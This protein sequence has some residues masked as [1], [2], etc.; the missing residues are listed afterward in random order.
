MLRLPWTIKNHKMEVPSLGPVQGDPGTSQAP[1]TPTPWWL[2]SQ[3]GNWV[4][5]HELWHYRQHHPCWQWWRV[6]VMRLRKDRWSG[7]CFAGSTDCELRAHTCVRW[8]HN[9]V[10]W[11]LVCTI[12][13][14][15]IFIEMPPTTW[16]LGINLDVEE[17]V[18][19]DIYWPFLLCSLCFCIFGICTL[20]IERARVLRNHRHW[21]WIIYK[22]RGHAL[23]P[24][25]LHWGLEV[26]R[27]FVGNFM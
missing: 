10:F 15:T 1:R 24:Q 7:W 2:S 20:S 5:R 26:G 25:S 3:L 19:D 12:F 23:S 22:G 16:A 27:L 17:D 21:R 9:T 18:Y 4:C 11:S 6:I 14:V 8:R 13:C